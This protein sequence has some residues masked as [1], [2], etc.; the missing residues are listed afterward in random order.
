MIIEIITMTGM[1]LLGWN[2]ISCDD[3]DGV[4]RAYSADET[5][6]ENNEEE[7]I[8]EHQSNTCKDMDRT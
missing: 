4:P 3:G 8:S 7:S 1:I 6:K 2:D 5:M